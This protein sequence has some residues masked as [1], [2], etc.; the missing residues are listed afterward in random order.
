MTLTEAQRAALDDVSS[1]TLN[2]PV[3]NNRMFAPMIQ[4][5][6]ATVDGRPSMVPPHLQA[7]SARY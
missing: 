7:S 4:F 1:P 6:G 5:A 3:D 2:F